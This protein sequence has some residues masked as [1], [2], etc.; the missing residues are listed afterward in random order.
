[1]GSLGQAPRPRGARARVYLRSLACARIT[2]SCNRWWKTCSRMTRLTQKHQALSQ[3]Q[4]SS[5]TLSKLGN[6]VLSRRTPFILSRLMPRI[7]SHPLK[8]Y[9]HVWGKPKKAVSKAHGE[10]MSY[11]HAVN[12]E[13]PSCQVSHQ[14]GRFE[15][16]IVTTSLVVQTCICV[17][18]YIYA[19]LNANNIYIY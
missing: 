14:P 19:K 10:F 16:V 9:Q 6:F 17:Y 8:L 12:H 4:E 13:N 3:A 18:I 1:M 7:G 2:T 11:S 15:G 5:T